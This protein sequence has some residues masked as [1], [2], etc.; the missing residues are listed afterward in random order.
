MRIPSLPL[1]TD[2]GSGLHTHISSGGRAQVLCRLGRHAGCRV[3]QGPRRAVRLHANN[4]TREI[5]NKLQLS[6]QR[7]PGRSPQLTTCCNQAQ[8]CLYTTSPAARS[9]AQTLDKL[10]SNKQTHTAAATLRPCSSHFA[11]HPCAT[12][13]STPIMTQK[14]YPAP[15]GR[16]GRRTNLCTSQP[17]RLQASGYDAPPCQPTM[18]GEPACAVIQAGFLQGNYDSTCSMA[19]CVPSVCAPTAGRQQ[20]AAAATAVRETHSHATSIARGQEDT[21]GGVG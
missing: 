20:M 10:G 18:C 4:N 7:E 1:H 12:M 11:T 16:A 2:A 5:N 6:T 17:A 8:S 19:T 9:T 3:R 15:A 21:Q 13:P 14:Q